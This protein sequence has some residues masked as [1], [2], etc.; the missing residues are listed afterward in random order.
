MY[1]IDELSAKNISE[2][3]KIASEI[4]AEVEDGANEQAYVY[5]ILDKQAEVEGNKNPLG[6][7][8]RRTRIAKKD[9]DKV[10]TVSGKEGENFD[11]KK[12]K[13]T[14]S[15]RTTNCGRKR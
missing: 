11:M 3:Q 8:R 6:T 7:K 9:T 15:E 13:T 1:S 12:N 4:G 5:A 14:P 10:Y 2:L